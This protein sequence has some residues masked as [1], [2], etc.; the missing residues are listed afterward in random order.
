M[1][2][3]SRHATGKDAAMK[4]STAAAL[5]PAS[6]FEELLQL[7]Q[8]HEQ[9]LHECVEDFRRQPPTPQRTHQFEIDLWQRLHACGRAL[10]EWTLNRLEPAAADMPPQLRWEGTTYR[11]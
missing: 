2:K 5:P 10:V 11:R 8:Q 9:A 7:L 3:G 6:T 4:V 1:V